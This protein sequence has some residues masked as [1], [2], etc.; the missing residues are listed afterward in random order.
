MS[1]VH[2]STAWMSPAP[3]KKPLPSDA[4]DLVAEDLGA[5]EARVVY[6]RRK[7]GPALRPG[8]KM[9]RRDVSGGGSERLQREGADTDRKHGG[10]PEMMEAE[11]T[12]AIIARA[13][14]PPSHTTIATNTFGANESSLSEN[15]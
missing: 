13:T 2:T 9:Y 5:A 10:G 7:G 8:W 14:A 15:P 12:E 6:G 11:T 1:A 3:G 4:V